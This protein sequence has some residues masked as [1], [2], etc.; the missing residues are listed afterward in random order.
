LRKC[1]TA[2]SHGAISPTEAPFSVIT[3]ASVKLTHK[4]SQYSVKD[5]NRLHDILSTSITP[6]DVKG[7]LFLKDGDG[8]TVDDKF[9]VLS[10][11]CAIE[12]A[13][14]GVILEHVDLLKAVA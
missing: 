11:G 10:L 12:F 7:I 3:P 1:L 6:F 4:T 9:P 2:G 13:V 8:L 5:T 14:G